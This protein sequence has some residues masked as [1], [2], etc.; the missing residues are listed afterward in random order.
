MG[1]LWHQGLTPSSLYS[2]CTDSY[3][4]KAPQLVC[5]HGI[6]ESVLLTSPSRRPQVAPALSLQ[7]DP[8]P[9]LWVS[10]VPGR[11]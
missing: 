11:R 1:G 10:G 6:G 8:F 2:T 3:L 4:L 7:P 5:L 9:I